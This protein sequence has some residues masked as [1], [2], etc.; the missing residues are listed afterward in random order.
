M[1]LLRRKPCVP[2]RPAITATSAEIVALPI[3]WMPPVSKD[4]DGREP[5][6]A[7]Q[8]QVAQLQKCTSAMSKFL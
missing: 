8:P 5:D 7:P 1:K 3:F 2:A 6:A 4:H